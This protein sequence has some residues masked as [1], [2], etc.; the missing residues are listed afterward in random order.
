MG[1]LGRSRVAAN[2]PVSFQCDEF[3]CWTAS[4]SDETMQEPCIL[5]PLH[6]EELVG[7]LFFARIFPIIDA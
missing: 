4:Q 7:P 3:E 6:D 1:Q 5:Y 2:Y